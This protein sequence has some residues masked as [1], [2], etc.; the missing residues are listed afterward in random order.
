M[1]HSFNSFDSAKVYRLPKV[2][3]EEHQVVAMPQLAASQPRVFKLPK[4]P[5]SVDRFY[6]NGQTSNGRVENHREQL[7][8]D[9]QM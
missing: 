2:L 7:A 6:L 8:F 4:T 1:H 5:D 3:G 9:D